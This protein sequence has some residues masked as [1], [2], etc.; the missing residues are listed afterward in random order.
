MTTE[1]QRDGQAAAGRSVIGG[2]ARSGSANLLGAV[3]GSVANLAIVVIVS[4]G[5]STSLAGSFF[6]VT[7]VFL[8]ILSL[9]ELGVGQGFVR[10]HARNLALGDL[11]ANRRILWTGFA[12]VTATS[13]AAAAAVALAAEHVGALVSRGQGVADTAQMMRVLALALPVAAA[14][15]LVLAK[16]RGHSQMRPTILIER[17]GRPVLQVVLLILAATIG[18]AAPLLLAGAWA[19]P[20][21]A[22]L[23]AALV[24]VHRLPPAAVTSGNTSDAGQVAAFWRFTAPRGVA[25]VFQVGL[26]RADIAIVAALAGPGASAVYTAAT[27]FLVLGQVATQA[28]Q[29]VSEPPLA[30]LIALDQHTA[31]R[32]IYHQLTLWSVTLA[33]PLYLLVAVFSEPLLM[34]LFGEA[35]T[36]GATS[37]TILALTMLFATAMGPVDVLLLMAGRSG[38]SLINTGT[39]LAIDVVGCLALIPVL[40][41]EGAAV[42]WAAAIVSRNVL[43]IIQVARHLA[44]TPVARKSAS[45]ALVCVLTFGAVPA[46]V[47]VIAGSSTPAVVAASVGALGYGAVVWRNA[48]A[49][50]LRDVLRRRRPITGQEPLVA[51][52][53]PGRARRR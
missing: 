11:T 6:A 3:V 36:V 19:L 35:Y 42:A 51:G 45:M 21:L 10:F 40:G 20:Y 31:V 4:R 14:Y 27:R 41:I 9:V 43:G 23:L 8:V 46:A 48:E 53:G 24:A 47:G 39:A 18:A 44:I 26:Q 30:R 50:A 49:L 15:E 17:I 1:R 34:M 16:T 32:A 37:L 22:G 7:S 12:A 5:W 33:W 52:V 38:L 25:R 28:L 29:Q 13:M 2:I